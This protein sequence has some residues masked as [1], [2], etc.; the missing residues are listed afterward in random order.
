MVFSRPA[1]PK[2]IDFN[3]R[4]TIGMKPWSE[5]FNNRVLW[6]ASPKCHVKETADH[7]I[8][9]VMPVQNTQTLTCNTKTQ[10]STLPTS[11][12]K[13][14]LK[15]RW[16]NYL[17][18]PCGTWQWGTE[19]VEW[20]STTTHTSSVSTPSDL[21]FCVLASVPAWVT[22]SSSWRVKGVEHKSGHETAKET[23]KR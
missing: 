21:R 1:Q 23:S 14:D 16:Y 13:L 17:P 8:Y 9:Q 15:F 2:R 10:P 11:N 18:F 12:L 20:L 6:C 5:V 22:L 19:N 4:W 7:W 3:I